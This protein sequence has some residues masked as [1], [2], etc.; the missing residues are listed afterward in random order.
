MTTAVSSVT[1]RTPDRVAVVNVTGE[2]RE[3]L[4][5]S[6]LRQGIAVVSVS[7]TTCGVAINEDEAGLKDD[8]VRLAAHL[9]DPLETQGP[10]RHDRVDDNA[11]AHLTSVLIGASIVVPVA[12]ADLSLGTWQSLFLLEM[13]GPRTRRLDVTFLGE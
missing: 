1:I 12:G 9:L 7:H 5:K 13:D 2:V 11:R 3:A 6:G 10:F 8:L 4:R